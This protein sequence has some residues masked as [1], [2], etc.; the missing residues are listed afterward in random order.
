LRQRDIKERIWLIAD[1]IPLKLE[2]MTIRAT[3]SDKLLVTGW[4]NKIHFGN[5]SRKNVLCELES[6][7]DSYAELSKTFNELNDIVKMNNLIIEF[8]IAYDDNRKVCIGICSEID[9]KLNWYID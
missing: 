3:D 6:L 7:K 5:L 2:N 8:H 1:G 9:G 4:T